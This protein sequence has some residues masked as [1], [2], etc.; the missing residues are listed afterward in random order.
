MG[1]GECAHVVP[2]LLTATNGA[3]QAQ[4]AVCGHQGAGGTA[5]LLAIAATMSGHIQAVGVGGT[6]W[7]PEGVPM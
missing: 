6:Q 4:M 2:T 3:H 5:A 1:P 7:G